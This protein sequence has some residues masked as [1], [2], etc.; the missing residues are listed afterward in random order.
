GAPADVLVFPPMKLRLAPV[1][2]S[3]ALTLPPAV[4][5]CVALSG[6]GGPP[7]MLANVKEGPMPEGELWNGV[8]FHPVYGY[9]HLV[10]QDSNIIG[11]WKRADQ[12]AWGDL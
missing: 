8:Y 7:P 9:L 4:A 5:L 3:L 11:K 1:L 12:S 2:A 6:C 10:E